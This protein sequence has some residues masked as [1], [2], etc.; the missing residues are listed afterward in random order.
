MLLFSILTADD[1]FAAATTVS[2]P[3]EPLDADITGSGMD[4]LGGGGCSCT[5]LLLRRSKVVLPVGG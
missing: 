3:L 4:Y 2:F 1:E 5:L